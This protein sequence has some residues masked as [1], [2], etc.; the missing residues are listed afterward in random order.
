[1]VMDFI[2]DQDRAR[3]RTWRLVAVF[4]LAVLGVPMLVLPG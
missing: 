3:S 1:M 2:G 4:I